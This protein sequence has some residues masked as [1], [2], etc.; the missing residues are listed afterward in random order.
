MSIEFSFRYLIVAGNTIERS[1]W[2]KVLNV[3]VKFKMKSLPFY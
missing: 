2:V 1:V 3:K